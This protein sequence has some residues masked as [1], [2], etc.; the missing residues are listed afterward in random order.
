MTDQLSATILCDM[1]SAGMYKQPAGKQANQALIN[2]QV[3]TSHSAPEAGLMPERPVLLYRER[4]L[5]MSGIKETNTGESDAGLASVG[6]GCVSWRM[7]SKAIGEEGAVMGLL[8]GCEGR[9]HCG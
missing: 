2:N 8:L 5:G 4:H 3:H 6:V 7:W 9:V 1:S